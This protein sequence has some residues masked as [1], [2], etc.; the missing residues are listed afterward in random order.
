MGKHGIVW[1]Q[2]S[3]NGIL[4]DLWFRLDIVSYERHTF[5]LKNIRV[6][7]L[8]ADMPSDHY[9]SSHIND[10]VMKFVMKH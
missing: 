5:N 6:L 9:V 3:S 1:D 2:T 8:S 4:V 10:D 7:T